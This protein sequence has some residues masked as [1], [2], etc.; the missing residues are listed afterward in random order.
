MSILLFRTPIAQARPE[1]VPFEKR[2]QRA[3]ADLR[4]GLPVVLVDDFDREYEADLIS[5]AETITAP[6]MAFFIH[7]GSG[8]V[9]L[10]L[11]EETVTR[12]ELPQMVSFNEATYQTAFTQSVDARH[13]ITSG[14]SA[15]DRVVTIRTAISGDAQPYDLVRPGHVFPLRS[16]VGGILARQ[17]HTEGSLE[18]V[19]M[20]G[21]KAAAVICEITN[22]DGTMTKGDQ[23]D[24]FANRHGLVVLSVAELVKHKLAHQGIAAQIWSKE[25]AVACT[26]SSSIR[27]ETI[28]V[29]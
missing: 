7:E 24:Q 13:G 17:G 19:R 11:P 26:C 6:I 21:L 14:V 3:L 8:I 16:A 20:A 12:L 27:V 10:C 29:D 25:Q 2:L 15:Q 4:Q 23:V 28:T 18:L 9:C 5:A 1:I 22:P